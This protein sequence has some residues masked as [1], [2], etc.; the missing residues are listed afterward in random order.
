MKNEIAN[1]MYKILK[2]AQGDNDLSSFVD[3]DQ[4]ES[5]T[6]GTSL[7][8]F[9]KEVTHLA[10]NVKLNLDSLLTFSDFLSEVGPYKL[11]EL[12]D[13]L[14]SLNKFLKE[15]NIGSY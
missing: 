5:S 11:S 3:P 2:Q 1:E 12:Q 13:R 8:H 9:E 10:E 15:N 6:Y 14:M 4:E 7:D